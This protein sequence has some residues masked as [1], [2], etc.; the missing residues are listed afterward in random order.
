MRRRR[1]CFQ[2]CLRCVVACVCSRV[3]C[4]PTQ[5]V[6]RLRSTDETHSVADVE[7]QLQLLAEHAAECVA[8]RPY[9]SC[10]TPAVWWDRRAERASN[11]AV[12]RRLKQVAE[13][14]RSSVG[15]EPALAAAAA[16]AVVAAAQ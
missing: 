12:Y 13:A 7:R 14:R 1:L 5:V 8:L 4:A 16:A 10:G 15:A 9:G 6:A 11:G 2:A 3:H